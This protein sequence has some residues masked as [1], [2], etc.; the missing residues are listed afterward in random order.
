[1]GQVPGH[2]LNIPKKNPFI[3]LALYLTRVMWNNVH[4]AQCSPALAV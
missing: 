2:F 4:S 1:M 3:L